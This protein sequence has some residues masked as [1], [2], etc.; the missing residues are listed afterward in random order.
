[1]VDELTPGQTVRARITGE[2]SD[3]LSP[4]LLRDVRDFEG[5]V[6]ENAGSSILIEIPVEEAYA[7]LRL[8]TLSQRV[9]IPDAVFQDVE[10]K[11]LDG[12]RTY[13]AVALVVAAVGGFILTQ[14]NKQSG[15]ASGGGPGGP[16]DSILPLPMVSVPAVGFR[17]IRR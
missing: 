17:W 3:S 2:F 8:Q 15:G 12:V 5:V 4:I 10:I 14:F 16:E 6:V 11:E 7:G 9:E 13:G 1:M